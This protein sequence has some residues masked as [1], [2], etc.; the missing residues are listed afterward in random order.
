MT[1]PTQLTL[2]KLRDEG[3]L[4]EVVEK[5]V[6]TGKGGSGF[7]RDLFGFLDIVCLK[8]TET[9]GVQCTSRAH[10]RNRVNKIEHEDHAVAL[11]ALREAGWTIQVLGW[12]KKDGH[13]RCKT[14]D[15]S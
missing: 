13:W 5:F 14:V 2:K 15:C 12:D 4:A 3:Y 10:V 6:R 1:S 8:G 11:A 7:R 9:L